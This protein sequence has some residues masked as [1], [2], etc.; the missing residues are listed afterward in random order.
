MLYLPTY[1]CSY[2]TAL[3]NLFYL[4]FLNLSVFASENLFQNI[5]GREGR[6]W[7]TWHFCVFALKQIG[8]VKHRTLLFKQ[9]VTRL[10][11]RPVMSLGSCG[12][13]QRLLRKL[14]QL[15]WHFLLCIGKLCQKRQTVLVS[16]PELSLIFY[17]CKSWQLNT[18]QMRFE[19][20]GSFASHLHL[21]CFVCF[22]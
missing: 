21:I 15:H 1:L 14:C 17:V 10:V 19:T 7:Y 4:F 12:H 5:V 13:L 9:N 3:A 16:I 20:L 11:K 2:F 8:K 18:S 22:F 6:C